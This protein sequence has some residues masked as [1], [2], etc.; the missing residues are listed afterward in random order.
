MGEKGPSRRI[1]FILIIMIFVALGLSIAAFFF[2]ADAFVGQDS[3]QGIYFL[4]MGIMGFTFLTYMLIQTRKKTVK[5]LIQ[6]QQVATTILCQ[7]CGFKNIRDFQRGDY[8]LKEAEEC[9]KCNEKMLI[10]SIYREVKEE[11]G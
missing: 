3:I 1:S 6:P 4:M 9:P 2:A 11:K 7:K 8:I 10:S 5:L